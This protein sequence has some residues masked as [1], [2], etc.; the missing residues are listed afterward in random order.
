MVVGTAVMVVGGAAAKGEVDVKVGPD[1]VVV[2]APRIFSGLH[3]VD[4]DNAPEWMATP[5]GLP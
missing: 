5:L 1:V 4:P 3:K 2:V